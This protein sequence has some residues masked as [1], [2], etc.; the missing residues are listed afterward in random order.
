M[1]EQLAFDL[2]VLT[3]RLRGDFFVSTANALAQETVDNHA[4][5]PGRKLILM[6]PE[7]AGKTHLASIW[8]ENTAALTVAAQDIETLDMAALAGR[9]VVVEDAADLAG[10]QAGEVALFHVHN[11]VL[12]EGGHLLLT[13]RTAPR[14][15]G[16][17]LP[18]LLSR[19][20]ATAVAQINAPDDA[21]LAMVLLKLFTD[22]QITVAPTLI[23][24]LMRRIDRS[25]AAAAMIV[26][27][28]DHAALAQGRAVSRN[29]AAEIL[30]NP[31]ENSA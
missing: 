23:P 16:I 25:L 6:G 14:D 30:D 17:A 21:L 5:W 15:W 8:A 13:A 9:N 20:S 24:Y 3:S 31:P 28:L 7:G 19:V 29:L 2:P 18:D 4:S 26:R 11:L 12:A 27:Q 10:N 1:P 22:R